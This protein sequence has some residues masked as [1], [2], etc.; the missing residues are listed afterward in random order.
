MAGRF[1]WIVGAITA[2]LVVVWDRRYSKVLRYLLRCRPLEDGPLLARC[3]QLATKSPLPE[4]LF[5]RADLHGGAVANALALPSLRGNA[6]LF[7]DTLLERLDEDEVVAICG[8]ELAHFE[9]YDQARLQR[10]SRATAA[11]AVAGAT[12][13]PAS[14]LLGLDS[15]WTYL[16]W[17]GALL[18]VMAFRARDKQRQETFCDARA[19]ELTGDPEPLVSGLTKLYAAARLPRRIA[20][21]Q[22]RAAS[23]PSLSRRIRD[24]RR[25]AGVQPAALSEAVTIYGC[26]GSSVVSFEESS[27]SW[28]QDAGVTQV[29]DY[30]HLHELRLDIGRRGGPRL[31]AVSDRHRS[32]EMRVSA[33]D[34]PRLQAVLDSVDGRLGDAP[35]PR[36][37]SLVVQ[38]LPR[39]RPVTA[40]I[41]DRPADGRGRR[42]SGIAAPR[43]RARGWSGRRRIR[44]SAA[45]RSRRPAHGWRADGGLARRGWR[46]A[47]DA[48]RHPSAPGD[49]KCPSPCRRARPARR[50]AARL[51][52]ARGPRPDPAAPILSSDP[53]AAG[54]ARV[55]RLGAGMDETAPHQTRG[56]GTCAAGGLGR[57]PLIAGLPRRVRKGSVSRRSSGHLAWRRSRGARSIGFPFPNR[58][59]GF[60]SRRRAGSSPRSR[61]RRKKTTAR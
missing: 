30:R 3:R 28:Q 38:P 37:P 36:G 6:V 27:L 49:A 60:S 50:A 47:A 32:W 40:R 53:G 31:L 7:T 55:D 59:R 11:I 42:P 14:R 20:A 10:I 57:G 15:I 34:V 51:D 22:D 13:T 44:R 12:M 16:C 2:G 25:T 54:A 41:V 39:R 26:D 21:P 29:I 18:A 5:L 61:T 33:V 8:H 48:R 56:R 1:D 45:R 35:A 9:Y 4:P 52:C 23:H 43:A 17:F 58:R 24:I 19:V 46:G